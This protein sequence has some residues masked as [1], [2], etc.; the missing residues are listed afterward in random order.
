MFA[1]DSHRDRV[2]GFVCSDNAGLFERR[3]RNAKPPP[4]AVV[5]VEITRNVSTVWSGCD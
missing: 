2:K 5:G 3:L 4:G 1:D